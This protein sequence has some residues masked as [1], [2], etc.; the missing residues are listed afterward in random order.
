VSFP[1][2]V[3]RLA[4]RENVDGRLQ[5]FVSRGIRGG[6]QNDQVKRSADGHVPLLTSR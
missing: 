3:E 4:G 2:D 6:E 1:L 5:R